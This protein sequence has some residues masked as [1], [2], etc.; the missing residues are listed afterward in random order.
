MFLV[1]EEDVVST[2]TVGKLALT[3]RLG[4]V[5]CLEWR[6]IHVSHVQP[7]AD[8]LHVLDMFVFRVDQSS[9]CGSM[10]KSQS[11]HALVR[12]AATSRYVT[13]SDQSMQRPKHI[14]DTTNGTGIYT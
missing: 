11:V 5:T 9:P 14:P 3:Y 7:H 8:F 2:G 12:H 6:R 13:C 10:R 4:C 1:D